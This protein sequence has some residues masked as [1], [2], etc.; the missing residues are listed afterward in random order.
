ML[1][2]V[3][4]LL[5][6]GSVLCDSS[7]PETLAP[8]GRIRGSILESRLGRKIYSFRGVRYAEPP[9]GPRR[10]QVATPARDWNDVFDA[11]EEGPGCPNIG[12]QEPMSEDCLRLNVYTTKLPSGR[13][14]A[15]RPVLVFFHPGGFYSFSGQSFFFGPQYLLDKDIVLVTVNYRLATL[16]FISTGDAAAPGNLGLKDQVEALRWVRRNIAA[17]GGDPGCVTISG[18]SVGG[19]SVMLHLVSPM[20][21]DLFHRAIV[22]SGSLLTTEP[23]PTE[24]KRLAVKQ[25]TLL[26]CP[27]NDNEAMIACLRTKPVQNFTDTI[28]EFFEWHG[29]P[30]VV[31]YPVVEPRVP[32]VERFLPDQPVNL[33][34][35][36]QFHQVPT[37]FGVTKD[38]FGGVVVAFENQTKAGNNYYR[39]MNDNFDRIAPISFMYE[40]GTNRSKY[41]SDQLRQFYFHGKPIDS[42]NRNGLAE[43]YADSVIIFPMHRGAKLF[44]ENSMKPVYFYEFAYQG[45]YSFVR[46]NATTTYGVVHHDDLQYLFFMKAIFPFFDSNAPE[47]PMVELYTS[48]WTTFV[49]TG[50]P[51]PRS[52]PYSNIRWDRFTSQQDNYLEINLNP[53]MRTGLHPARMREWEKLF[54]L[55]SL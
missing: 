23:Y 39:D 32:G 53:T 27:T 50:V 34:R 28:S 25:A 43:L 9:T 37:I 45:R 31:W 33:I 40:R 1:L 19:L 30:I 12:G 44:A 20:S 13:E 2:F 51:V 6:I 54:P 14:N 16:G 8:T 41:D 5:G 29:D 4:F 11:T 38:E 48:M 35:R 21:K 18:Y 52:G 15:K 3:F 22:M 42:N 47:I 7:Q 46:W 24:Q 55:P 17:F 36:G 26:N 10:F 49:E